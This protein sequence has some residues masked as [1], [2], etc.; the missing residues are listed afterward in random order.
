M[1]HICEQTSHVTSPRNHPWRFL[2]S[3][4]FQAVCWNLGS[5]GTKLLGEIKLRGIVHRTQPNNTT[6][7]ASDIFDISNTFVFK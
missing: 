6:P 7:I 4:R 1:I 2:P 5:S 3:R